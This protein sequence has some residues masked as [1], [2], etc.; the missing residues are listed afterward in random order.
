MTEAVTPL[1]VRDLKERMIDTYADTPVGA[2][3]WCVGDHEVY[4]YETKVGE[5]FGEAFDSFER[6]TDRREGENISRLEWMDYGPRLDE[7]HYAGGVMEFDIASPPLRQ[8]ATEL[9]VRM[10]KRTVQQAESVVLQDVELAITYD[11]E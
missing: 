10:I 7:V 9:E 5:M 11:K 6:D 8:R 4:S 3:C 1:A 2:L